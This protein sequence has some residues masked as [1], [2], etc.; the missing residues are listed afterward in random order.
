MMLRS[1]LRP[2]SNNSNDT[3][4]VKPNSGPRMSGISSAK[5]PGKVFDKLTLTFYSHIIWAI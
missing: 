2:K 1:L 4:P 5:S 3:K